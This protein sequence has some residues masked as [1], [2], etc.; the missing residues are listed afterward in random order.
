MEVLVDGH[1]DIE[2][3]TDAL[4]TTPYGRCVYESGNDVVDHQVRPSL[5]CVPRMSA[6]VSSQVVN[7][8]FSSGATASLTMVAF[9]SAICA[10][11]SRLHFSH[12]EI[13]GDMS[14]FTVTNFTKKE[15]RRHQPATGGGHGG[16]DAMLSEAFVQA[17]VD[18]SQEPLG[19]DVHEVL[20]SHLTV[21]AAEKS[22]REGVVVDLAQFERQVRAN[23]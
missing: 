10:R 8:E 16:G 12:G 20:K 13:I 4:W 1:P 22:R 2:N 9:T 14:S 7:L 21:F 18:G 17:I 11:Q 23:T 15:T 6:Y 19:T 3:V 5:H